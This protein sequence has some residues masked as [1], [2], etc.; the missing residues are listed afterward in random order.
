MKTIKKIF[1][2]Q[3]TRL[4]YVFWVDLFGEHWV[5]PLWIKPFLLLFSPRMYTDEL[6]KNMVEVDI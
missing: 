4:G 1:T 6:R 5:C 3:Y 2:K